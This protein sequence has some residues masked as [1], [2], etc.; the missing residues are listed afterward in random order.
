MRRTVS[1]LSI[2]LICLFMSGVSAQHAAAEG[3]VRELKAG[4]L[5][6]DFDGM[7][8]GFS[9]ERRG[10]DLNLELILSPSLPFLWGAIRPAVGGTLNLRGDT[11]NVYVD[12]RWEIEATSGIFFALG[13]GAALHDGHLDPDAWDRKALGSRVLFHVPIELGYRFDQHNSLS[14]YFEHMSNGN[15]ASPNEGM[16]FLGI[17]YGYRF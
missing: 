6:H 4:A 15:F 13:I 3:F 12:A 10:V 8:S 14:V 5:A 2:V 7:W 1:R 17:R 9:L 16:D 11:S